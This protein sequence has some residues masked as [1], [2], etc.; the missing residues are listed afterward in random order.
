[1]VVGTQDACPMDGLTDD[2]EICDGNLPEGQP[3]DKAEAAAT[4][5]SCEAMAPVSGAWKT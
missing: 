5:Q 1:M 4:A 3:E 2:Y